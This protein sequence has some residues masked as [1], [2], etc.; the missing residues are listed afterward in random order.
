MRILKVAAFIVAAGALAACQTGGTGANV[1][2]AGSSPQ[3]VALLPG[4]PP[5]LVGTWKGGY[6]LQSGWRGQTQL[7][8][9]DADETSVR[10][11]FEYR[12]GGGGYSRFP[13]SGEVVGKIGSDGALY[14]GG[15]ELTLRRKGGELEFTAKEQVAGQP[16]DLDWSKEAGPLPREQPSS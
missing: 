5:A 10:G 7:T 8:L 11:V 3:V 6:T 1:A 2:G 13:D 4:D 9:S 16:A 15:W 12:W 14:F